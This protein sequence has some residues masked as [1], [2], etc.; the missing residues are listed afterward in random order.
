MRGL[1][2]LLLI[3]FSLQLHAQ[4]EQLA[5]NYME[6]GEYAKAKAIYEK[7]FKKQRFNSNYFNGLIASQQELEEYAEVEKLLRERIEQSPQFPNNYIELGHNFELQGLNDEA[8]V[9]YDQALAL[10]DDKP[11]TAYVIGS[12]FQKYNKLD[13]AVIAFEKGMI[14]SP[15]PNY[16]LQLARLYGEQG[17]IEKMFDSYLELIDQNPQFLITA[18]RNIEQFI[19]DDAYNESNVTLRKLLLRRYFS[20]FWVRKS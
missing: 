10:I 19:T 14:T 20:S 12:V 7:L 16:S 8:Q 5:R 13:E 9:Y 15:S 4:S 6:Q 11:N 3:C 18:N 17:N 2:C 1:I